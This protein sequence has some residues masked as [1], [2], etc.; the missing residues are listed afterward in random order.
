MV[1]QNEVWDYG[2]MNAY[3]RAKN[4]DPTDPMA[5]YRSHQIILRENLSDIYPITQSN[6]AYIESWFTTSDTLFKI[7]QCH[8]EEK[9]MDSIPFV[10][11][12]DSKQLSAF[13]ERFLVVPQIKKISKDIMRNDFCS[14]LIEPKYK[15]RILEELDVIN[16]N[17]RFLFPELEYTIKHIKNKYCP[18]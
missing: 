16:V 17:E 2:A 12:L 6:D 7:C 5:A 10:E 18:S 4:I 9:G 1:F 13:P 3:D 14:I 15:K 8:M 11:L